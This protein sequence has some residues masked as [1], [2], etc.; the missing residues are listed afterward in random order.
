MK[1]VIIIGAG[2]AGLSAAVYASQA[3]FEAEVYEMHSIPG[4]ECTGWSR[5]GYHIDNCIHWLTGTRRGT[6]LYE[7]WENLGAIG[8]D[9]ELYTREEYLVQ[10]VGDIEVRLS[11]DIEKMRAHLK[12]IS[13]EDSSQI[14]EYCDAILMMQQVEMP[15][16]KPMDK[17]NVL[18]Y[19]KLIKKMGPAGKVMQKLTN[20]TMD[21]YFDAFKHPA[22]RKALRVGMISEYAAYVPLITLATVSSGN[23]AYPMGGSLAM[24]QRIAKRAQALGAKIHY[25]KEVRR[26]I[27]EN[28]IAI[29]IELADGTMIKGDY[30]VPTN[31]LY[32][33]MYKL[34]EGKYKDKKIDKAYHTPELYQAPTSLSIGVGVACDLS[35]RHQ[36]Y[37][38]DVTPFK[39][40]NKEITEVGFKLYCH[41]KGFAPEGHSVINIQLWADYDAWK[42]LSQDRSQYEQ[43]K[44]DIEA[45]IRA[46]VEKVYPETVGKIEMVDIATP[47]TYERYCNAYKGAWMSFNTNTKMKGFNHS[48]VLKGVKNMYMAGQWLQSPGGLP[49]A[50]ATGKWAIWRICKQ[51]KII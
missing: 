47:V 49:V 48:G 9:I 30:I 17:L 24:A 41:E 50:G 1:K 28:G 19:I 11:T 37:M 51:E 32:V 26:I 25:N 14:D 5:K 43:T 42:A 27:V 10:R 20:M 15:I 21:E 46:A 13:P 35:H 45:S 39:A 44:Q 2:I 34:L 31:D 6:E 16:S 12:E 29:G 33:T 40:L 36:E 22:L 4:G 3:G 23:G 18:D 7:M 8:E 38:T